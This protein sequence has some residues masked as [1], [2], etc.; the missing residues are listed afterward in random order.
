MTL[1]L[2]LL[3]VVA[4]AT[5]C[6]MTPVHVDQLHLS[7]ATA[8]Q[9]D[10]VR[11]TL[12]L[13][14]DPV[15]IPDS[16]RTRDPQTKSIDVHGL[17]TFVRRDVRNVLGDYFVDVAP[18]EGRAVVAR[19]GYVAEVRISRVDT[20]A[21]T[22]TAIGVVGGSVGV[23]TQHRAVGMLDWSLTIR[24]AATGAVV[25]S[26]ADRAVGSFSLTNVNHSP[27]A[28]ASALETA[29]IRLAQDLRAQRIGATLQARTRPTPAPASAF[30][31]PAPP[32]PPVAT[33]AAP[34]PAPAAPPSLP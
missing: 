19:A 5:G 21:D 20:I 15:A 14:I 9:P 3:L 12:Y 31:S 11:E 17:Q 34:A 22:S 4:L 30:A 23:A 13:A 7:Y 27:Q 25:Y 16:V 2:A 6:A 28:I 33:P 8:P 10:R 1:R 26:F 32:P 18:V 24:D 29:L